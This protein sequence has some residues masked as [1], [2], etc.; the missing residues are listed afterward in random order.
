MLVILA[1]IE[2]EPARVRA[3]VTWTLDPLSPGTS[4]TVVVGA[5]RVRELVD[6]WLEKLCD[7][8]VTGG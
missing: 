3:R 2:G 8:R 6:A 1:W 7:G 4:Q 5:D